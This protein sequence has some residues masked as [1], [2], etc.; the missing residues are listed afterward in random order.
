MQIVTEFIA[1]CAERHVVEYSDALTGCMSFYFQ[2]QCVNVY[3]QP[4]QQ[5]D[6]SLTKKSDHSCQSWTER[7]DLWISLGS[8]DLEF[9][10]L[11]SADP[12]G[13]VFSFN[14]LDSFAGR[15]RG[16]LLESQNFCD[17]AMS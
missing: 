12:S 3:T 1:H 6:Q 13:L 11:F 16:L 17:P 4:N 14:A 2:V 15:V 9:G 7:G 10:D 5:G 8:F